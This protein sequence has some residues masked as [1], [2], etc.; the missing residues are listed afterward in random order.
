M[1][2]EA[3]PMD[4]FGELVERPEKAQV[5]RPLATASEESLQGGSVG[6]LNDP[7]RDIV[8]DG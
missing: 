8:S 5:D 3:H 1:N 4:L 6:G 2:A 7:K